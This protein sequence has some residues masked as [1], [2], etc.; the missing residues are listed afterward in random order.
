M[1]DE[2]YH[3]GWQAY[4][5]GAN[6]SDDKSADWRTGYVEAEMYYTTQSRLYA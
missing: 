5:M 2:H 3:N 6:Y 1:N 4:E